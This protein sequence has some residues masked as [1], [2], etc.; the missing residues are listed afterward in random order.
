MLALSGLGGGWRWQ[1]TTAP[2]LSTSACDT[3]RLALLSWLERHRDHLAEESAERLDSWEDVS[4]D[5]LEV[6]G[7]D[8]S[9]DLAPWLRFAP[10]PAQ[11][12]DEETECGV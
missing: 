11:S 12:E 2:R 6:D 7:E 1:L 8:S 4:D 9:A 10:A 3:P 5:E